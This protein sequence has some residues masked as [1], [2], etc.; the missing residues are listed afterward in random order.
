MFQRI[1]IFV[2]LK[3]LNLIYSIISMRTV[4]VYVILLLLAGCNLS[5]NKSYF[6]FLNTNPDREI[7]PDSI[8]RDL[9]KR[10]LANID[11]LAREGI[12]TAAGP[13]DDGGGI[14]IIKANNLKH[15][16]IILQTDPA[17]HANRFII[18]IL[19][20]QF[21]KGGN[22]SY[23]EPVEMITLGFFRFSTNNHQIPAGKLGEY[24]QR[25][26]E[27]AEKDDVLILAEF[28]KKGNGFML[29]NHEMT[30][31]WSDLMSADPLFRN[32]L[33]ELDSRN[34]WIAMGTFCPVSDF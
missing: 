17:I 22:C 11:S 2:L 26:I 18:E 6:V 32:G 27:F 14:F 33:M 24:K 7:L 15:A 21:I 29:L 9:Q 16:D 8:V 34:L 23:Y 5:V 3:Y 30:E 31:V 13:F 28:D 1:T 20:L 10:H 4:V 25:L 12:I 19:P